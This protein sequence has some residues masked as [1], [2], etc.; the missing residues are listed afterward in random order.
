MIGELSYSDRDTLYLKPYLFMQ[1]QK[2]TV[3]FMIPVNT[4]LLWFMGISLALYPFFVLILDRYQDYFQVKWNSWV[5]SQ[6]GIASTL[7]LQPAIYCL[8]IW[9]HWILDVSPRI[10]GTILLVD[11][12]L[13]LLN[14]ALSILCARESSPVESVSSRESTKKLN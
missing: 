3:F 13:C 6:T 7:L 8:D 14:V 9:T 12:A 1:R 11:I 4:I 5:Q 10:A 2:Q